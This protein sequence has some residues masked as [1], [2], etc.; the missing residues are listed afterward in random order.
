MLRKQ[1]R[2]ESQKY[3]L[4]R[5]YQKTSM[6]QY[7]V[8][9]VILFL[10]TSIHCV[11]MRRSVLFVNVL[12]VRTQNVQKISTKIWPCFNTIKVFMKGI[13]SNAHN[14]RKPSPLIKYCRTI[15]KW[16]TNLKILNTSTCVKNMVKDLIIITI[17]G[18]TLTGITSKNVINVQHV[19]INVSQHHSW[20]YTCIIV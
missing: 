8:Q 18:N 10:K 14:V 19:T 13:F 15:W 9:S 5:I 12:N 7:I 3:L 4:R 11:V 16:H 17:S 20:T 2:L 6:I 1:K